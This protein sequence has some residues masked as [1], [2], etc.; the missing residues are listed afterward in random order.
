MAE[1]S[2]EGGAKALPA[3]KKRFERALVAVVDMV[4]ILGVGLLVA[5]G[6]NVAQGD[7]RVGVDFVGGRLG[8]SLLLIEA[9]SDVLRLQVVGRDSLLDP[10]CGG[11]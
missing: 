9:N 7:I 2:W 11:P 4:G 6:A 3:T 10:L 1:E 5:T 8:A